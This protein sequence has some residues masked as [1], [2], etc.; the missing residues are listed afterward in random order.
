MAQSKKYMALMSGEDIDTLLKL[1]YEHMEQGGNCVDEQKL[2]E[3]VKALHD[4][5]P[6]L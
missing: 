2:E 5:R 1:A 4:A 3:A 6:T